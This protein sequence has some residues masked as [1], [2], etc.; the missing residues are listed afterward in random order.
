MTFWMSLDIELR[1]EFCFQRVLTSPLPSMVTGTWIWCRGCLPPTGLSI[2]NAFF[3]IF[4]WPQK[5]V[6]LSGGQI[7]DSS[8]R[9][10]FFSFQQLPHLGLRPLKCFFELLWRPS[11]TLHF[12]SCVASRTTEIQGHQERCRARRRGPR[13][14]ST[15]RKPSWCVCRKHSFFYTEPWL[16]KANT[17]CGMGYCLDLAT[18]RDYCNSF[19]PLLMHELWNTVFDDYMETKNTAIK[20]QV[21]LQGWW[22]LLLS[23]WPFKAC[24][25]FLPV[26]RP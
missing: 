7:N 22:I 3:F 21:C 20:I 2:T 14:P 5:V 23:K 9:T 15:W 1:C 24:R 11:R 17:Y 8:G 12:A 6:W 10:L 13:T 4:T 25:N 18:Y 19:Y 16:K 26:L